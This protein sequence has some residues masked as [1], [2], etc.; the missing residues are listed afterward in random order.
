MKAMGI[1]IKRLSIEEYLNMIIP[2]LSK[3]IDDHKDGWK[4]QLTMEISFV[5]VIKGSNEGSNEPYNIHIRSDN[6]F[7]FIGYETNNIIKELFDYL[8]KEYQ[9][10]LKTNMKRSD[11][12][13]DSV[14]ALYYKLHKISLNRGGSYIDS[15]KWLKN[16]NATINPKNKKD[17]KCFHY[18]ITA[19][20]NHQNIKYNPERIRKIKSFINKCN[21][22][23]SIT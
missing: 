9:K 13:F 2:H 17:N 8:L 19:S 15:P 1:K 10:A 12:V 23:L 20:L 21:W 3:I 16:K 4:T 11:L 7:I 22:K 18:A 14:E 5:P 6:S